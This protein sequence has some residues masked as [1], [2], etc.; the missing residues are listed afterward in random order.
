MN[1]RY[2]VGLLFLILVNPSIGYCQNFE[3]DSAIVAYMAGDLG[4]A[5]SYV[6]LANRNR[7]FS[8]NADMYLYRGAIYFYLAHGETTRK[9][10]PD[11]PIIA[12]ESFVKNRELDTTAGRREQTLNFLINLAFICHDYGVELFQQKQFELAWKNFEIILKIIPLDEHNI[13]NS[14]QLYPD[15]I[16]QY[17]AYSAQQAGKY[18]EALVHYRY[19]MKMEISD[20]LFYQSAGLLF[21]HNHDTISAFD[22]ISKGRSIFPNDK[23]LRQLELELILRGNDNYLKIS[24]L[25]DMIIAEPQ[26]PKWYMV[27]ANL[28]E[29]RNVKEK[30]EA[31]WLKV[32]EIN[33]DSAK[34]AAFN[35]GEY[36]Y[37]EAQP[38]DQM[39]SVTNPKDSYK[40][41]P[42]KQKSE[43]LYFKSIAMFEK[44]LKI[45]EDRTTLEYLIRIYDRLGYTFQ[46]EKTQDRLRDFSKLPN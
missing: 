13:L 32:L 24:K 39:K 17:A 26:N 1:P 41:K 9:K 10:V 3:L 44:V 35:L 33:T 23:A 15:K 42:L 38:Y 46:K 6:D 5:K 29:E 37:S 8:K 36:Y 18:E 21:Y 34:E 20:P 12:Y 31:D 40:Y 27:R 25:G 2:W 19:L 7:Q 28:Y 11:A 43:E 14:N 16:H 4:K 22:A 30:S 45:K